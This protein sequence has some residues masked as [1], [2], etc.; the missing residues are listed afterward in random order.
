[1]EYSENNLLDKNQFRFRENSSKA[2]AT[3]NIYDSWLKILMKV[4]ALAVCF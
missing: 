2:L 1:M 3:S 4:Y